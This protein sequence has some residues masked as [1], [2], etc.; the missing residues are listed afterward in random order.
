MAKECP[1]TANPTD[2][3]ID[4]RLQALGLTLPP[5]PAAIANYV[6]FV[7]DGHHLYVSGQVSRAADGTL[8]TGQLGGGLAV[9]DGQAAARACAL[10]IPSQAK[11]ALGSL[12]RIER[13]VRLTGFVNAAAG[14]VDHP[15]VVN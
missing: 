10:N 3:E 4:V 9:A 14:F 1:M 6:P 13:I 15:A 8:L 5:A 7:L 12:A 11:A 2:A